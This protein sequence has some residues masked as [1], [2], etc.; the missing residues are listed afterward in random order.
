MPTQR[1]WLVM[2]AVA[3][4]ALAVGCRPAAPR[5][6]RPIGNEVLGALVPAGIRDAYRAPAFVVRSVANGRYAAAQDAELPPEARIDDSNLILFVEGAG[7][8]ADGFRRTARLL[9]ESPYDFRGA[10]SSLVILYLKW[11]ESGN[12]VAEHMNQ[13]AQQAGAVLLAD[14]LEVHRRRYP[15]RGHVSLVGFSAGT[16]VIEKAFS[17]AASGGDDWHPEAFKR[18][19]NVVFLGSSVGTEESMPLV[20]IR[21]RFINFVNPRDTH[22]GD[23]AAYVAV[24]GGTADPLKLLQQATVQRRP[25]FGASVAGFRRLPVLTGT[26]QFDALEAMA[27]VPELDSALRAFKMVNVPVPVTLVAFNLFGTPLL[28]DDLDDYLNQAPNHYIMVGRGP[29]GRTDVVDF[30]QYRAAAEE[31]VRDFV[32]AAAIRGRLYR[33]DLKAVSKGA[34]PLGGLPVPLPVPWALFAVPEKPPAETPKE[35]PEPGP[36][37]SKSPAPQTKPE[38]PGK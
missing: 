25:R 12:P 7:D 36:P 34:N 11:C 23:R 26:D 13:K 20:S 8:T 38:P 2:A 24:A 17:G 18:V 22:F 29:A 10:A 31:F 35:S 19:E 3:G 5:V 28:D 32:G 27:A 1:L 33:F 16:R 21:G 37:D 6:P 9:A 14:M 30:R 4:L 15:G